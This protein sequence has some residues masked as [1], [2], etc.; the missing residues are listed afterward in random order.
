MGVLGFEMI[1]KNSAKS[2]KGT[3]KGVI[4]GLTEWR[5]YGGFV[6]ISKKLNNKKR[7][8]RQKLKGNI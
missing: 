1:A 2:D 3:I 5:Y 6:D 7:L 8:Q 4:K